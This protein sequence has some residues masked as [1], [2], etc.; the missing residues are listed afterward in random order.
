MVTSSPAFNDDDVITSLTPAHHSEIQLVLA[1]L[2]NSGDMTAGQG[3]GDTT[4]QIGAIAASRHR[5]IYVDTRWR[6]GC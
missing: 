4:H 3:A 6:R 1:H 5:N 2:G